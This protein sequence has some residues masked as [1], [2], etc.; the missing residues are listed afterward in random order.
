METE[1]SQASLEG[2]SGGGLLVFMLC[3]TGESLTL[4]INKQFCCMLTLI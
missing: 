2:I 3:I 4:F 1:W